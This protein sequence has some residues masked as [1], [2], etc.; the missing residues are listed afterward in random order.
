MNQQRVHAQARSAIL[1]A[2]ILVFIPAVLFAGGGGYTM[3]FTGSSVAEGGLTSVDLSLSHAAP[4]GVQGFS[5]GVCHDDT[6]LTLESPGAAADFDYL[7]DWSTAVETIKNGSEPDFFQQN[8]ET[9]GWTVGC[10]IC[11]TSC[12]VMDAGS[13]PIGTAFYRAIGPAGSTTSVGLCNTLGLP[14]VSSV[15]VVQGA[16]M[17]MSSDDGTVQIIEQP[18]TLFHFSAPQKQVNYDPLDGIGNFSTSLTITEDPGNST[19]PTNTQGFSMSIVGDST[20]VTPTAA[21][22]TGPVAAASPAF[23]ESILSAEGWA[24]GVV[25]A[26]QVPVYIQFAGETDA[27]SISGSTVASALI[28]DEVGVSIP[29]NWQSAGSPP[30]YNVVTSNNE[31]VIPLT[32]NGGLNLNPQSV[33]DYLR[34]DANGDGITNVADAIW[35]LQEIFNNG[36][37]GTCFDSKDTNGDSLFDVADPIW[38]ITYIFSGGAQPPSPFPNCGNVGDPQDCNSYNGC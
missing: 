34:G 14:P 7:I 37:Q 27:M 36:P 29:L 18:P 23:A 2:S 3:S 10:V 9:G 15:A 17:P 12:A 13:T 20:F 16:S 21:S 11:F 1:V 6:M 22:I 26:F 25:Y 38:L 19:Y 5:F 8:L 4:T 30:I 24:I 32:S 31:S 35:E 28:G 33:L